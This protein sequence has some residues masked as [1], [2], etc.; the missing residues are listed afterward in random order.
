MKATSSTDEIKRKPTTAFDFRRLRRSFSGV[1]MANFGY[2]FARAEATLGAGRA[3]L[4]SFG[5]LFLA[6]PDLPKRLA[7]GA[8]LNPPDHSTFYGGGEQ[9]YTDYPALTNLK[10]HAYRSQP[11]S[12]CPLQRRHPRQPFAGLHANR[13]GVPGRRQSPSLSE[14]NRRPESMTEAKDV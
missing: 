5:K 13:D 9:G 11:K 8:P 4:I 2:T 12:L 10:T 3:D 1:Y 7:R 6:N 14:S